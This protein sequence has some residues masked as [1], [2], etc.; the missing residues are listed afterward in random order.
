MNNAIDLT[1]DDGSYARAP[2]RAPR[3]YRTPPQP[4]ASEREH[5]QYWKRGNRRMRKRKRVDVYKRTGIHYESNYQDGACLEECNL[6]SLNSTRLNALGGSLDRLT[7]YEGSD[8]P[9]DTFDINFKRTPLWE[10]ARV[11]GGYIIHW[12]NMIKHLTKNKDKTNILRKYDFLKWAKAPPPPDFHFAVAMLPM[13]D[14]V[15]HQVSI[16]RDPK[17]QSRLMLV[18]S[19][20]PEPTPLRQ[21]AEENPHRWEYSGSGGMGAHVFIASREEEEEDNE[22]ERLVAMPGELQ[23]YTAPETREDRVRSRSE[24]L[25][26]H[27]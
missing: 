25:M 26:S 2:A 17:K 24:H 4:P 10:K 22:E 19:E 20:N 23:L 1:G 15:G 7:Q 6:N 27:H 21:E 5:A 11:G 13:N 16:I 14:N 12:E 18:D 9:A 3:R 8:I